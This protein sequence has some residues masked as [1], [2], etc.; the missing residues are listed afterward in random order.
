MTQK[1]PDQKYSLVREAEK[2]VTIGDVYVHFKD[3]TKRYRVTGIGIIEATEEACVM[4]EAL[5]KELE[6]LTWVRPLSNF[7]EMV[8]KDGRQVPRFRHLDS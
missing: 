4:Y 3:P 2:K 7:V 6:G 1:D 5:Y 8:E